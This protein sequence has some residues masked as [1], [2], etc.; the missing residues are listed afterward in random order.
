MVG[1]VAMGVMEERF[2]GRGIEAEGGKGYMR[3][4]V[5]CTAEWGSLWMDEH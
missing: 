1:M 5:D 2:R 3:E 4:D